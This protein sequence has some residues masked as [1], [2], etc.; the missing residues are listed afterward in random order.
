MLELLIRPLAR[1]DLKAIWSYT[2]Q[3]WGAVQADQYLHNLNREVQELLN[4]PELGISCDHIRTGY[5]KLQVK[6]HLVFYR[7]NAQHIEIVRVLHEA[8]DVK[9]HF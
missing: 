9:S 7:R 4:F 1:R 3:Q 2:V 5:R 8:M 6:R